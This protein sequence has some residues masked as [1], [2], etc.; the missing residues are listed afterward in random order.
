MTPYR[1]YMYLVPPASRWRRA[2]RS[3]IAVALLA[4]EKDGASATETL[5]RVDRAYPFG[6]RSLHPYKCWLEERR[7]AAV[8]LGLAPV[9]EA[10]R[11]AARTPETHADQMTLGLAVSREQDHSR[12]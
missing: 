7:L 10:K 11:Q 4:A 6:D 9:P 3:A 12:I 8:I 2:A 1:R 5:Q